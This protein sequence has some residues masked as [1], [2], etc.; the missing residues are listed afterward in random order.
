[1]DL[2]LSAFGFC[3]YVSG[4]HATI[5]YDEVNL[6]SK[7]QRVGPVAYKPLILLQMSRHFELLN[8]SEYGT[9]VDNVV[10]CCDVDSDEPGKSEAEEARERER[11]QSFPG[12]DQILRSNGEKGVNNNTMTE[13]KEVKITFYTR[14]AKVPE[15]EEKKTT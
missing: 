14:K 5:F 12:L 6:S 11:K 2:S 1:M 8:Y 15:E 7:V 10:Y 3:R 9:V 4:H 13:Q